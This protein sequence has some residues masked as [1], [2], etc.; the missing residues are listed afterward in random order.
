MKSHYSCVLI[1]AL[2][3]FSCHP[4]PSS[5]VDTE[6]D[7][8]KED[9]SGPKTDGSD[10]LFLPYL[11]DDY[12]ELERLSASYAYLRPQLYTHSPEDEPYYLLKVY[13]KSRLLSE[14]EK[15]AFR[16]KTG[17][18]NPNMS[19]FHYPI[20]SYG[21][22]AVLAH[23][24]D[25]MDIISTSAFNDIPAGQSLQSKI[26]FMSA[27]AWPVIKAGKSSAPDNTI[28]KDTDYYQ[29]YGRFSGGYGFSIL[30]VPVQGLLSDLDSDALYL[31]DPGTS[32][33]LIKEIPDIKEHVFTITFYEGEKVWYVDLPITFDL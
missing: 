17:E 29:Y 23:F 5:V 6:Q 11:I 32:F 26:E 21:P 30:F 25:R 28:W 16:Q 22:V 24:F 31:L 9:L 7:T 3:L 10:M 27:S 15:I 8:N 4:E 19:F 18:D 1:C 12:Y 13:Y 20:D 33:F 2:C 14:G